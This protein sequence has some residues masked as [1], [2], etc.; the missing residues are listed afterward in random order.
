MGWYYYLIW[1]CYLEKVEKVES[2]KEAHQCSQFPLILKKFVARVKWLKL[3]AYVFRPIYASLGSLIWISS[4][5]IKR[6]WYKI[7]CLTVLKGHFSSKGLFFIC[8]HLARNLSGISNWSSS[9]EEEEEE[10]S[11]SLPSLSEGSSHYRY[12]SISDWY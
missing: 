8:A 4:F 9:E 6:L 12:K 1:E 11:L 3:G 2:S 7:D 5:K 10:D